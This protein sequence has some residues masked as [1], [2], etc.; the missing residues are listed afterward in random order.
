LCNQFS[1]TTLLNNAL[2]FIQKEVTLQKLIVFPGKTEEQE[3]LK[4]SAAN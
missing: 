4:S 3:D 2:V 1:S